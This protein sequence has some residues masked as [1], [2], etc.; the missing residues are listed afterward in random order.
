MLAFQKCKDP[1]Q[2]G[3]FNDPTVTVLMR[4]ADG[5]AVPTPQDPLEIIKRF[6]QDPKAGGGL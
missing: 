6:A 4:A 5:N 3:K 1:P 2:D